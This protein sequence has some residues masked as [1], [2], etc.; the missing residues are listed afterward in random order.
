MINTAFYNFYRIII[1]INT[2]SVFL[3]IR[4]SRVRTPDGVPISRPCRW[5]CKVFSL[6]LQIL[7]FQPFQGVWVLSE[8]NRF[9]CKRHVLMFTLFQ[10]RLHY[11]RF[12]YIIKNLC[13]STFHL[14]DSFIFRASVKAIIIVSSSS[15]CMSGHLTNSVDIHIGI[16]HWRNHRLTWF[17]G[18]FHLYTHFI[19]VLPVKVRNSIIRYRLIS[20]RKNRS[21]CAH[22]KFFL[23][24][25]GPLNNR[26]S[27]GSQNNLSVA[28]CSFCMF[29]DFLRIPSS[30][31][32]YV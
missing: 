22:A 13:Q 20:Y 11:F 28:I 16:D 17:V 12:A 30:H 8:M 7:E 14:F 32:L 23:T 10:K 26:K 24:V 5:F 19:A 4:V 9:E 1:L 27:L 18:A 31:T 25:P 29:H 21:V 2:G 3:L 6:S 15:I